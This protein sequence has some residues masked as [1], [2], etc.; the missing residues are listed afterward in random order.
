[1][2]AP[3]CVSA[4]FD[5]LHDAKIQLANTAVRVNHIRQR[6]VAL[7]S[8]TNDRQDVAAA[9]GRNSRSLEYLH[10]L[11]PGRAACRLRLRASRVTLV[12]AWPTADPARTAR[13]RL[14]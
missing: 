8:A 12:V 10:A 4:A 7:F 9:V 13:P 2:K 14:R 1:M 6:Y 11:F 3:N 5:F